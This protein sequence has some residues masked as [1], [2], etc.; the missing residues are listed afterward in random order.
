M[1]RTPYDVFEAI[2]GQYD[3][4]KPHDL[5]FSVWMGQQKDAYM[6]AFPDAYKNQINGHFFSAELE[7]FFRWISETN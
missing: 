7:K 1:Y 3:P 2:H 6:I 4:C 5:P